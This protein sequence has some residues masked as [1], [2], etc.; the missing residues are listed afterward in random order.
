MG[1]GLNAEA[2]YRAPAFRRTMFSLVN[3]AGFSLLPTALTR[4]RRQAALISGGPYSTSR[5]SGATI[6]ATRLISQSKPQAPAQLAA[7]SL[8]L[9]CLLTMARSIAMPILRK[10]R[11]FVL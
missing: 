10:A 11:F 4:A 8:S 2:P 1:K 7:R 9:G 3:D 5:A 6:G